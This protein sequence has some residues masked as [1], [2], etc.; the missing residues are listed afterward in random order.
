MEVIQT[1]SIISSLDLAEDDIIMA[2]LSADPHENIRWNPSHIRLAILI[3][4]SALDISIMKGLCPK[5]FSVD[6]V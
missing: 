1:T 5:L 3:D 4:F 2:Y 6:P